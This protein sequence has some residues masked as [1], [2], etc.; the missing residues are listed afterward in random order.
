MWLEPV[1]IKFREGG[2]MWL[3]PVTIKF[4]ERGGDCL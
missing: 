1:T 2:D 3:E 4:R